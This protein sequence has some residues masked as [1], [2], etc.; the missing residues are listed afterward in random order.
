LSSF[1]ALRARHSYAPSLS[2]RAKIPL[3]ECKYSAF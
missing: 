3:K 2:I 1:L